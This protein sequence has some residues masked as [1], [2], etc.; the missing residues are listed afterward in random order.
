MSIRTTRQAYRI[1][2]GIAVGRVSV[3]KRWDPHSEVL[4][5]LLRNRLERYAY[6]EYLN[7]A[8]AKAWRRYIAEEGGL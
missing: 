5:L 4:R 8:H 2:V 7:R 3:R 6:R 1:R